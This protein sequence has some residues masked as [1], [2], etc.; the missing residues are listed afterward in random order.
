[1]TQLLVVIRIKDT[2]LYDGSYPHAPKEP[3]PEHR[4][5]YRLRDRR[6]DE[7]PTSQLPMQVALTCME[8]SLSYARPAWP[9]SMREQI[10]RRTRTPAIRVT[11]SER[12]KPVCHTRTRM[13]RNHRESIRKR[14]IRDPTLSP[15]R[16]CSSDTLRS[17]DVVAATSEHRGLA[18]PVHTVGDYDEPVSP[19]VRS[20]RIARAPPMPAAD[21]RQFG[22]WIGRSAGRSRSIFDQCRSI[23]RL[24]R[25]HPAVADADR[26]RRP[27]RHRT[28][29]PTAWM[30]LP[31][32]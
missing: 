7:L 28:S 12:A 1:M 4:T 26:T 30:H 9:L 5:R 19:R 15:G 29:L 18:N 2:P 17:A 14:R 24:Y 21:R 10:G 11:G 32:A 23:E 20:M 25:A 3:R 6:R 8:R 22:A 27:R 31:Y 13:P 16:T